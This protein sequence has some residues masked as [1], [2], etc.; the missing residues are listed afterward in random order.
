MMIARYSKFASTIVLKHNC[1]GYMSWVFLIV[2]HVNV[3]CVCT[4]LVGYS[5]ALAS[6]NRVLLH[7]TSDDCVGMYLM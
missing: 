3:F 6:G 7:E 2:L 4:G 5:C 1:L